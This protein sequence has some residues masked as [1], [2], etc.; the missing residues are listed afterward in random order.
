MPSKFRAPRRRPR[1]D[2]CALWITEKLVYRLQPTTRDCQRML[3]E[4]RRGCNW[5]NKALSNILGVSALVLRDWF[6]GVRQ[7]SD[8][9]RRAIWL[10]WVLFLYPERLRSWY[11]VVT[12]GR[13]SAGPTRYTRL[14]PKI[15]P[16]K[17]GHILPPSDGSDW[18]I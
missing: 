3:W 13:Y 11:D 17:S 5:D 7:P 4:L 12:W 14:P 6:K 15:R 18:V 10:T 9:A 2:L 8:A 16:P 1:P